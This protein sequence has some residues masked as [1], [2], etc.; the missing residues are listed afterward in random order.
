MEYKRK[1]IIQVIETD[2]LKKAIHAGGH[3]INVYIKT[4][5]KNGLGYY[6]IKTANIKRA[7]IWKLRK[8]CET[9]IDKIEK[10]LDPTQQHLKKYKLEIIEI[11]DNQTLRQIKL[12]KINK[13]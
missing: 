6:F 1:F 2:D 9:A 4:I 3:V 7:K 8:R 5:I 11:T 10:L 12:K 13:K